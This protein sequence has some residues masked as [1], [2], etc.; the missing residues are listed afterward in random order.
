MQSMNFLSMLIE[1]LQRI[2][3]P[4][5]KSN[6][7]RLKDVDIYKRR[8]ALR[9]YFLML[10]QY[11]KNKHWVLLIKLVLTFNFLSILWRIFFVGLPPIHVGIGIIATIASFIIIH[12]SF[13]ISDEEIDELIEEEISRIEKLSVEESLNIVPILDPKLTFLPINIDFILSVEKI[14]FFEWKEQLRIEHN[15]YFYE[16][17][18]DGRF[19]ASIYEIGVFVPGENSLGFLKCYFHLIRGAF[20]DEKSFEHFYESI[21]SVNYTPQ[22]TTEGLHD[23]SSVEKIIEKESLTISGKDSKEIT[24]DSYIPIYVEEGETPID[25]FEKSPLVQTGHAIRKIL[26]T[27]HPNE[28]SLSISG[29]PEMSSPVLDLDR[30]ELSH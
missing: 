21:V 19:R 27:Y 25:L 6:S 26:R 8:K 5:V 3:S 24:F 20:L 30:I 17:G 4:S 9:K 22:V 10:R 2:Y 18:L 15:D 28:Q 16:K 7:L 13:P 23:E 12:P 1:Y 14:D 29:L 11:N